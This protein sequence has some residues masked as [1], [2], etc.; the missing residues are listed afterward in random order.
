VEERVEIGGEAVRGE[1]KELPFVRFGGK[2]LSRPSKLRG[3]KGDHKRKKSN[4]TSFWGPGKEKAQQALGLRGRNSKAN[5]HMRFGER[6]RGPHISKTNEGPPGNRVNWAQDGAGGEDRTGQ[7][8]ARNW[9][10]S[11]GVPPE[12]WGRGV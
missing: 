9:P 8:L 10:S 4:G 6:L 2:N 1:N 7:K 3:H 11:R 5:V 12:K